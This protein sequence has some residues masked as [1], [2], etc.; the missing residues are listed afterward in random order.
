MLIDASLVFVFALHQPAAD[1]PILTSRQPIAFAQ[2]AAVDQTVPAR[3]RGII[4][5]QFKVDESKVR[6]TT[7]FVKDLKADDLAL[8]E[9]VMAYE[10]E[11]KVRITEAE[12]KTFQ[13]VQDVVAFL[14]K[15][16]VPLG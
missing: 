13:Q 15:K 16:G 14:R 4:A 2:N 11:F 5:K 10:K 9:L 8:V 3:L 1:V 12:V 7:H 6:A